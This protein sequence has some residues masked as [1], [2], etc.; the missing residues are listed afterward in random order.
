MGAGKTTLLKKVENTFTNLSCIDLDDYIFQH[1]GEGYS[2][3]GEL[4][5]DKGI[6]VF[7]AYEF[8]S[9]ATLTRKDNIIIALGGGSLNESTEGILSEMNGFWLNTDFETCWQRIKNDS[10]RPLV[11]LGYEELAL[12]YKERLYLYS[13]YKDFKTF[14]ELIKYLN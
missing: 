12:I 7:R 11:S 5:K 8:S 2:D 10:S 13:K 9:L 14:D 6:D 3:I 4:I 1:F